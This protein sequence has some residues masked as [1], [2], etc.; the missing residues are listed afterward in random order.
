MTQ[1]CSY[2]FISVI[3]FLLFISVQQVTEYV[4]MIKIAKILSLREF[5]DSQ[6]TLHCI[7]ARA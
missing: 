4:V 7:S 3:H 5:P 1:P 6:V 2:V